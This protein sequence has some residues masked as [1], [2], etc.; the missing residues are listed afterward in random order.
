MLVV[1]TI[2][3]SPRIGLA[4]FGGKHLAHFPCPAFE[5]DEAQEAE[6]WVPPDGVMEPV[7]ASGDGR[8]GLSA[9]LSGDQPDQLRLH[10]LEEGEEDRE[11]VQ[12]T[13]IPT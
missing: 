8:L 5:S 13:V 1:E 9:V 12:L 7:D 4:R 2:A 3:C 10:G 11:I 6:R